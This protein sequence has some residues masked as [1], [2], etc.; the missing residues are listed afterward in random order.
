MKVTDSRSSKGGEGK[1]RQPKELIVTD[2]MEAQLP[3]LR[4]RV[5]RFRWPD[6]AIYVAGEGE[7]ARP[8]PPPRE[9]DP[10]TEEQQQV[11]TSLLGEEDRKA[12][13][14]HRADRWKRPELRREVQQAARDQAELD[15]TAPRP[16]KAL[17]VE[18]TVEVNGRQV[19]GM[20]SFYP[21]GRTTIRL[22]KEEARQALE[23]A[24]E[25]IEAVEDQLHPAGRCTCGTGGEGG[26]CPWCQEHGCEDGAHC[27]TRMT[28]Q[29]CGREWVAV[30]PLGAAPLECPD[31]GGVSPAPLA[32]VPALVPDAIEVDLGKPGGGTV[33][34]LIQNGEVVRSVMIPQGSHPSPS[35]EELLLA[36][37]CPP[38]CPGDSLGDGDCHADLRAFQC[39]VDAAQ[40]E[41]ALQA[42]RAAEAQHKAELA[43]LRDDFLPQ[44][45]EG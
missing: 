13:V 43:E 28:C 18:G 39:P 32:L 26:T 40:Q 37:E 36:G 19:P 45:A 29:H 3:G 35:P 44:P 30:H 25:R 23:G 24:R 21:D 17:H 12:E 34:S 5:E 6:G 11:I 4:A 8:V 38:E 14:Y 7:R 27:C 20:V 33:L 42:R 1:V 31:C 10:V 15:G 9:G 41:A 22:D 16:V 2:A